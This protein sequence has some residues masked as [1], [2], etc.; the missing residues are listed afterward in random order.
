MALG[1]TEG[2]VEVLGA[3]GVLATAGLAAGEE[4]ACGGGVATD[5]GLAATCIGPSEP[6]IASAGATPTAA[7]PAAAG[8]GGG[9]AL[10]LFA[11]G[12]AVPKPALPWTAE[13]GGVS[14]LA[15]GAIATVELLATGGGGPTAAPP[16]G[17]D[18]V[19]LAEP[20][21]IGIVLVPRISATVQLPEF[22]AAEVAGALAPAWVAAKDA[23]ATAGTINAPATPAP[24]EC[25]VE[26]EAVA[27]F[28]IGCAV[29]GA[30]EY[31][32]ISASALSSGSDGIRS[33]CGVPGTLDVACAEATPGS[34]PSPVVPKDA[35][36]VFAMGA[37]GVATA[38]VPTG[39]ADDATAV[40]APAAG[41][42]FTDD[43][44]SSGSFT[45]SYPPRSGRGR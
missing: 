7:A 20:F 27:A 29:S 5:G 10:E 24:V 35:R 26:L 4:L 14:A 43:A 30:Y 32:L 2:A 33:V 13:A 21:V 31:A 11:T 12:R 22:V 41:A 23:P 42:A 38:V 17:A 34:V 8:T 44:T 16:E 18:T 28:E 6:A 15:V 9:P 19:V 40:A 36:R 37:A 25:G 39:R 3:D 1:A 45:T